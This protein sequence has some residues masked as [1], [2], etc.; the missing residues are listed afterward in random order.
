M[1]LYYSTQVFIEH[2]LS[3]NKWKDK[4]KGNTIMVL[5][6]SLVGETLV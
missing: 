2:L 1:A 5:K 6:H 3:A 4:D